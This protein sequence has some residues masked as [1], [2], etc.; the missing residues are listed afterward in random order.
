MKGR[1][2]SAAGALTGVSLLN[3]P[4]PRAQF[5]PAGA[6]EAIPQ[7]L[8]TIVPTLPY[9]QITLPRTRTLPPPVLPP[10]NPWAHPLPTRTP[11][12]NPHNPAKLP[13][14]PS[15]RHDLASPLVHADLHTFSHRTPH[16]DRHH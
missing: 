12:R 13:V 4:T 6:E 7:L 9:L 5:A 16:H 11:H 10:I 2:P 1:H 15:K 3:P 14:D 8:Q